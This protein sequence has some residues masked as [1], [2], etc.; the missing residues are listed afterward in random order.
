MQEFSAFLTLLSLVFPQLLTN[1]VFIE[2]FLIRYRNLETG[3]YEELTIHNSGSEYI[4]AK[5]AKFS[6]YQFF[7]VPFFQSVQGRPSNMEEARTGE[8]GGFI[9][10]AVFKCRSGGSVTDTGLLYLTQAI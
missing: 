8:D 10:V 7:L 6:R 4:V 9:L 1:K 2:G 5:L 3:Q